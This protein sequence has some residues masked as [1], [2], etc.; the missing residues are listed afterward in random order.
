[1]KLGRKFKIRAFHVCIVLKKQEYTWFYVNVSGKPD[2]N[3]QGYRWK[4]LKFIVYE[5]DYYDY[6]IFSALVRSLDAICEL[7]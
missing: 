7:L 2:Y 1:M 5:L 3:M 4:V 6:N